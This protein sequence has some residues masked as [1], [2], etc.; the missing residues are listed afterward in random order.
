MNKKFF[1]IQVTLLALIMLAPIFSLNAQNLAA[2]LSGKILLQVE[3]SGEAWYVNPNNHKRYFLGRPADAFN[4]M[5]NFGIGMSNKDFEKIPVADMNLLNGPDSD[6]DG[7]SDQVEDAFGTDKNNQDTDNDGYNDKDE[8]L[9]GYDPVGNTKLDINSKF[10]EGKKGFIYIQANQN[11]EAWYINPNDGKRYFLGH[12]QDAFNV[13]RSLGLGITEEDLS[14]IIKM[15]YLKITS[16]QGDEKLCLD[17]KFTI[18]WE[19]IGFENLNIL[20]RQTSGGSVIP[21]RA[22]TAGDSSFIW[23]VGQRVRGGNIR[24]EMGDMKESTGWQ[25]ILRDDNITEYPDTMNFDL[26]GVKKSNL[27]TI[28]NCDE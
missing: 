5:K 3:K 20:I 16:P 22:V 18:K 21:I 27:F 25:I 13:M 23:Q 19:S 28:L 4:I 12:P 14:K 1:S 2:N 10:V 24:D 9:S 11:G 7:L 8:I 15:E 6:I 26:P 17:D